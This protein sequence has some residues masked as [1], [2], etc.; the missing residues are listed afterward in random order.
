VFS[1]E[2]ASTAPSSI[3][4]PFG[5][6]EELQI[7]FMK[8]F[9]LRALLAKARA[10]FDAQTFKIELH[11][12][13]RDYSRDIHKEAQGNL[14]RAPV[15]FVRRYRRRVAYAISDDLIGTKTRNL[16]GKVDR[17]E[18]TQHYVQEVSPVET[19]TTQADEIPNS[20]E[21]EEAINSGEEDEINNMDPEN[22]EHSTITDFQGMKDFLISCQAFSN[23]KTGFAHWF[24]VCKLWPVVSAFSF[25]FIGTQYRSIFAGFIAI[26]WQTYTASIGHSGVLILKRIATRLLD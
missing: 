20:D 16:G 26:G 13:L 17:E 7:R 14:E 11:R 5:A 12:L 24:G 23:V 1:A 10:T 18:Y 25:T 15:G 21:P 2:G 19:G 9:E 8:D 3:H 4:D 6:L 22:Q